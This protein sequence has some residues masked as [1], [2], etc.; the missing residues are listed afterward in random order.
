MTITMGIVMSMIL[1]VYFDDMRIINGR[2]NNE[3]N[4]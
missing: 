2:K 1:W 4:K 3:W